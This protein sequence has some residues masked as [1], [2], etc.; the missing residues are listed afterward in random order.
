MPRY[1]GVCN[2]HWNIKSRCAYHLS[3]ILPHPHSLHAHENNVCSPYP[4]FIQIHIVKIQ[5]RYLSTMYYTDTDW[6]GFLKRFPFLAFF[7]LFIHI[8]IK[9]THTFRML[10]YHNM[11]GCIWMYC[12]V[13]IYVG[14]SIQN[15][16][17]FFQIHFVPVPAND[18]MN[19]EGGYTDN[20]R[21][22]LTKYIYKKVN[23]CWTKCFNI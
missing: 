5:C 17:F 7:I 2:R 13:Y 16:H 15:T 18:C 12:T 4:N 9:I 1:K 8:A 19:I 22:M 6:K 20:K 3:N 14:I 21:L 23:G 11:F 10:V